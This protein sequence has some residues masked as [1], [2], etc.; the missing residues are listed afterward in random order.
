MSAGSVGGFAMRAD[1]TPVDTT[2]PARIPCYRTVC[3][4]A[5]GERRWRVGQTAVSKHPAGGAE[6]VEVFEWDARL[7]WVFSG[8]HIDRLRVKPLPAPGPGLRS[9]RRIG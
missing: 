7:T 9:T 2:P 5:V 1:T 8:P 6:R 3:W 4:R